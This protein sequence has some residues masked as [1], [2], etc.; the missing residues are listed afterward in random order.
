M[1]IPKLRSHAHYRVFCDA[2]TCKIPL[3]MQCPKLSLS[4]LPPMLSLS[5]LF[6]SVILRL[7]Q[8]ISRAEIPASSA[9]MTWETK[10]GNDIRITPSASYK[11]S[12]RILIPSF[13]FCPRISCIFWNSYFLCR[14]SKILRWASFPH[15]RMKIACALLAVAPSLLGV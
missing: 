4:H 6:S 12:S 8:R 14:L 5:G 15:R 11:F 2:K 13:K 3:G 1:Q 7:D 10:S 9:G